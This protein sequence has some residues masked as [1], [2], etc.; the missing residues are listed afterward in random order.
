MEYIVTNPLMGTH[1]KGPVEITCYPFESGIL[2]S[3]WLRIVSWYEWDRVGP[4][5]LFAR[6]TG[7]ADH[8]LCLIHS[9][10]AVKWTGVALHVVLNLHVL[11]QEYRRMSAA[12]I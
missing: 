5:F 9:R 3:K 2:R 10:V 6:R 1:A 11:T 4:L 12:D 8:S 7:V